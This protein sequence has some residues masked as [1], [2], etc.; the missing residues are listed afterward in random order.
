MPALYA[1][2]QHDALHEA[3]SRLHAND[4]VFAFLD[5]IYIITTRELA[6]EAIAVVTQSISSKAGVQTHLGKLEVWSP[7]GGAAPPGVAQLSPTAW[8]G[9]APDHENGLVILGAPLGHP[10]F[11]QTHA[12]NRME[13]EQHLLQFLPEFEDLQAAWVLLLHCASPRANHLLRLLPPSA[14]APCARSHDDAL[15]ECCSQLLQQSRPLGRN[16]QAWRTAALPL[17]LGGGRLR[18]AE[19]TAPAA[20]S[21]ADALPKVRRRNQNL[22]DRVC[23]ELE[24]GGASPAPC[25]QEVAAAGH[26]LAEEGWERQNLDGNP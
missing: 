23:R 18:S 21:W 9:D 10:T 20:H 2:G 26:L 13:E 1:L 24:A 11:V 16:G 17:R 22:A 8:K 3:A 7:C 4:H 19:R 12:E 6:R 15:R 5:D 25:F 14:S